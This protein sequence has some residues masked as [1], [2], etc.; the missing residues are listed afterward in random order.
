MSTSDTAAETI[1]TDVTE[2]RLAGVYAD[3]LIRAA[4]AAGST[5]VLDELEMFAE[6]VLPANP[7]IHL[8]LASGVVDAHK[9]DAVL[10]SVLGGRCSQTFVNFMQVLN[11]HDRLN[12]L[13]PI[14]AG[15]RAIRDRR[16]RRVRV[17]VR[18][19]VPLADDQR[20]RLAGQLRET[21][22]LEP[23]LVPVVDPEMIGGIVLK[24]GDRV[25]DDSV[26]SRLSAIRNHLIER[27]SY[28]IQGGRNRFS[29]SE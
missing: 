13:R 25:L 9:K 4:D 23:V 24:I 8:F 15:V 28:E 3:A 16:E 10:A 22:T 6:R 11:G 12:L 20:E 18:T 26:R 17:E 1:H 14:L 27:G 19:A 2:Q 29:L 7:D 21:Y 5:E